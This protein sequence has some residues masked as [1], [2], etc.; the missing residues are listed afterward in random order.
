MS[1][2]TI[3]RKDSN[4]AHVPDGIYT[5]KQQ[6]DN[7]KKSVYVRFHLDA[8]DCFE[9]SCSKIKASYL[10]LASKTDKRGYKCFEIDKDRTDRANGSIT[11][12]RKGYVVILDVTKPSF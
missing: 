11:K 5:A 7:G 9:L 12:D 10:K 3:S 4:I 2:V 8:S 6:I 1:T